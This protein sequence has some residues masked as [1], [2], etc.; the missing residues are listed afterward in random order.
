MTVSVDKSF[1]KIEF[2]GNWAGLFEN[3][4]NG[5]GPVHFDSQ[6]TR[7][8]RLLWQGK[9]SMTVDRFTI[10]EDQEK[11]D[12]SNLAL[13][14]H[15]TA[16]EDKKE[17]NL[18]MG[19]TADQVDFNGQDLSGWSF[20]VGVNHMDAQA[21]ENLILLY[22]KITNQYLSQMSNP[23]IQPEEIQAIMGGAMAK[24]SAQIMAE[25]EKLLKKGLEIQVSQVDMKLPQG[26]IEGRF[27]LGLK[28]NISLA[29]FILFAGQPS[30]ALD[31]FS[32]ESELCMPRELAG[33]RQDLT[34]PVFPGMETGLFV[35][36]GDRL[37]HGAET[38]DG[39]LYLNGTQVVLD[40]P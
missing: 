13:T 36:K 11:I 5:I 24:N 25:V 18:G 35:P 30:L 34:A 1:E 4:E 32:L 33:P 27:L 39:K 9:G 40:Q 14:Y 8:T 31:Y 15:M 10:D 38:K 28:K 6:M 16:T 19:M 21:Y 29:Q 3:E 22:S 12:L 20:Q 2:Q 7:L 17:L 23:N 37:C 26:K